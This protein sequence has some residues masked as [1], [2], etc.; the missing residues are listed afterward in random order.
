MSTFEVWLCRDDGTRLALLDTAAGFEYSIALHDV[1]ACSLV[2]P[3]SFDR[4][5][6]APDRKLEFWRQPPNGALALERVY[7][8]RRLVSATDAEGRATI[9]LIGLD[10]N[11]LLK[12]RIVAYAAGA[13]QASMTDQADDMARAVVIDNLGADATAARQISST[14]LTIAAERSAGPSLTLSFSR[15]NVLEVLKDVAAAAQTAGTA[16]YWHVVDATPAQWQFRTY[17]GQPGADHSYPDGVNPVLLSLELGNLAEPELDEDYTQEVTYAYAGGQGEGADRVVATAEDTARSGR[18]LFGRC[19][20][21]GDSR[22]EDS[23][24]GVTA[25]A[26]RLLDEGRP[27]LRFAAKIVDSAGNRYGIHWRWGD[28]VTAIYSGYTFEAIVRAIRVSVDGNGKEAIDARLE[29]E[30]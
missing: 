22:N 16:V 15:D 14:Y 7:L 4:S 2:L 18:S 11:H 28:R 17:T 29:V 13:A 20:G 12:R 21:W 6:L 10:G 26:Q 1:G 3:G 24:G 27:K 9:K 5:L 30:E 8:I 25:Q 19:E 23:T